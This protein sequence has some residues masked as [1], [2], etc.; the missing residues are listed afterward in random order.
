MKRLIC[1]LVV[2]ETV[3]GAA[4]QARSAYI[5]WTQQNSGSQGSGD[6][7]QANLDG[8]GQK[9]L[10]K[11]LTA[12]RQLAIDAAGGTMS[13]SNSE[14]NTS[15]PG[16]IGQANL[17]GSNPKVLLGGLSQPFGLALDGAG[18]IYWTDHGN[19]TIGR[20]NLDGT[21]KLTFS[22]PRPTAFA[23]DVADGKLYWSG[24][25]LGPIHAANLDGSNPKT[26]ISNANSAGIALD[27][28]DGK[29]YWTDYGSASN[30]G[31]IRRANLDGTD[32]EILIHG[33]PFPTGITL[34]L[35]AGQFYWADFNNDVSGVGDIR[36]ANLD[37][38]NPQIL[39]SRLFGPAQIVIVPE[40]SGLFFLGI[41]GAGFLCLRRRPRASAP[42]GS[43]KL[44]NPTFA[45]AGWFSSS[46]REWLFH[47]KEIPMR[48][49][50]KLMLAAALAVGAAGFTHTSLADVLVQVPDRTT[51][52]RND[53]VD[54]G[55]FGP[56][57]TAV[58]NP[59]TAISAGGLSMTVSQQN[60]AK[61][62]RVDE[63]TSWTGTFAPGEHLIWTQ[64][65]NAQGNGPIQ[66]DFAAPVSAVGTRIQNDAFGAFDGTMQVT[67]FSP[68]GANLGSVFVASGNAGGSTNTAPFIGVRDLTGANIASI[69]LSS[70]TGRPD[71]PTNNN[72]FAID[73]LSLDT[74]AGQNVGA[75]PLP[76]SAWGGLA[77]LIGLAG[78]RRFARRSADSI[79]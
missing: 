63:G 79:G 46:R 47:E 74:T 7:R 14:E 43:M 41:A 21:G 2:L 51:L 18:S 58:P 10:V 68:G 75:T 66:I 60:H 59:S 53:T 56:D 78:W 29:I 61:F 70:D 5:L 54:W 20:A 77:L 17:D 9:V 57:D 62:L 27:L 11:G 55:Q 39:I 45:G 50:C 34:E 6:I 31:D 22:T 12:P 30:S 16:D 35:S 15:T 64:Q 8:S 65:F 73:A 36:R 25:E 24:P 44:I 37:G 71:R 42:H 67:A 28:K 32:P 26:L 33:L 38:S 23:L 69:T 3:L 4:E 76:A 1:G 40:P 19:S 48:S 49:V 52:A 72:D 13:W